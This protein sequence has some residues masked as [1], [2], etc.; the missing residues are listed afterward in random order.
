MKPTNPSMVVSRTREIN[1]PAEEIF[2]LLADPR[3]HHE[4]DGSGSVQAANVNA[5]ARL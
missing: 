3:R 2:E 1:A 4:F 5:P